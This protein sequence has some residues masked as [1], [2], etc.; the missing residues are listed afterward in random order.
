M[1]QSTTLET[2]S[3]RR[4]YPRGVPKWTYKERALVVLALSSLL[5]GYPLHRY[6]SALRRARRLTQA[7]EELSPDQV[8]TMAVLAGFRGIAVDVLWIKAMAL[9]EQRKWYELQTVTELITKLQPT[10]PTV[11]E[12]NAW[13]L[14]YN[15]SVEWE[16]ESDQWRW[17]KAGLKLLE[18]GLTKLPGESTL[19]Y[20]M[21]YIYYHKIGK[22]RSPYFRQQC[23]KEFGQN[24]FELAA[25]YFEMF[26]R[27]DFG[28][29]RPVLSVQKMWAYVFYS[30]LEWAKLVEKQAQELLPGSPEKRPKFEEA[31]SLYK[32]SLEEI[33]LCLLAFPGDPVDKDFLK[34][35]QE[36]QA[37]IG[38]LERAL[39]YSS[40]GS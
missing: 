12:F 32:K 27:L 7:T 11:W 17:V 24:C 20:Q 5:L 15:I 10:F 38:L 34:H 8:F 18:K 33:K 1:T 40:S 28:R 31:L 23:E 25:K 39:G 14:S 9:Q 4:R 35:M 16:L 2:P 19:A 22:H 36:T 29:T 6:I 37:R 26:Q 3:R 21:G 13:N 30:Y